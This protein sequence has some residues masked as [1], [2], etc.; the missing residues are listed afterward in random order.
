[1]GTMWKD[2][3]HDA[4]WAYHIAYKTPLGMFPYQ[5]VYGKTYHLPVELE[6]KAH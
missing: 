6:F 2:K 1:M 3:L 5:I 4:L